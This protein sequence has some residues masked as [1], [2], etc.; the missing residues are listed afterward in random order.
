M[1]NWLNLETYTS[2]ELILFGIGAFFWLMCY[3][4]IIR[5]I[6]KYKFVGISAGVVGANIAWEFLWAFVFKQDMGKLLQIGYVGWFLLDCYIVYGMFK[7]GYKQV[8]EKIRPHFNLLFTFSIIGWGVVLYYFTNGFIYETTHIGANSAYAIQLVISA[9]CLMMLINNINEP[10]ISYL[11]A[12]GRTLGSLF[13][14]IMCIM[15]WKNNLWIPSMVIVYM[16]IDIYYLF[17]ATKNL[18]TNGFHW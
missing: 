11:A 18:K 4:F 12:W 17:L 1:N 7:Y 2:T 13:C 10:G 15:H 9:T 14:G 8:N 6:I 5:G 3:F 16:V